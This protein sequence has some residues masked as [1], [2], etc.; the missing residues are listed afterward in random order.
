MFNVDEII[1]SMVALKD[2]PEEPR[3]GSIRGKIVY[4]YGTG[5]PNYFPNSR[6]LI[7]D[8]Y[9]KEKRMFGKLTISIEQQQQRRKDEEEEE[10]IETRQ[11]KDSSKKDQVMLPL[12]LIDTQLQKEVW[13]LEVKY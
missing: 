4:P 11:L 12:R 5:H 9:L 8:A 10:S 2:D 1:Q 7:T 3:L 13:L 6:Y